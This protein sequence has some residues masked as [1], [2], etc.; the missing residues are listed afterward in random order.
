MINKSV[1]RFE[2]EKTGKLIYISHLDL[3][4][5][6][7]RIMRRSGIPIRYSEGFNPHP[8]MVFALTVSVGTASRCELADI[9][10]RLQ[11]DPESGGITPEQF[12][13]S[14]VPN[15]PD[16]LHFVSCGYADRDFADITDSEYEINVI[17]SENG[18][19]EDRVKGMFSKELVLLK[20]TKSG[21]KPTDILP[22]IKS[23]SAVQNGS[24]L[25]INTLL[26]A[27]NPVYLNPEYI[28]KALQTNPDIAN[29]IKD[30]NITRTKIIFSTNED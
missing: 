8:K 18:N 11:D 30:Y 17:L 13:E 4:R 5:T 1:I 22:M 24:E 7:A 3:H 6:M 19:I 29:M 9:Y 23:F 12:K 25:K 21:E 14:V 26:A 2:F 28:I 16:G 10:I 27:G 15:L 20:R